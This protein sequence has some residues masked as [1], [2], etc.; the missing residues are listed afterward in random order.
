MNGLKNELLKCDT[1]SVCPSG[2]LTMINLKTAD[3]KKYF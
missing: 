2:K 1:P 3:L